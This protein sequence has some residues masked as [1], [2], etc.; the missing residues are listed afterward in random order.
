MEKTIYFVAGLPRSGSTLFMNILNQNPRFYG[1]ASSG[2]IDVVRIIRNGWMKNPFFMAMPEEERTKKKLSTIKG[3]MNGY[4]D[5]TD[6]PVVFDKNR[7][8][9]VMFELLST[10][11]GGKEKVKMIICVRDLRDVLASFEKLF[12]VTS[13]TS[14][15]TQELNAPML[16][17]TAL[18]RAK[19]CVREGEPLGYALSVTQDAITRGW[20]NNMFFLEYDA[21]TINPQKAMQEIYAFLGEELYQHDFEHVEQVTKEDDSVHGF[22]GLHDIRPKIEQQGQQ[23]KKVFDDTVTHTVFWAEIAKRNHFWR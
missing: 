7:G 13:K 10:I 9:P 1:T 14:T 18:E 8:W 5:G 16:H 2:L 23:W 15:T 6:R 17:R 22:T 20:R 12:R 4:F 11:F 21:L 3:A 19:F